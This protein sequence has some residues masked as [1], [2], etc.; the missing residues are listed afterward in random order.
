MAI[1]INSSDILTVEQLQSHIKVYA[2][3][4]AGKTHFLVEN[5]KNIVTINPLVANSRA[6]K[7]LCI[8]YTNAAVEEIVRRLDRFSDAVEAYTI[9]GFIIEHIIKPFQNDLRVL[10][11]KYFNIEITGNA[12]ITSQVEGLGILHGRDKDEIYKY[13]TDIAS[14]SAQP[15]Y[16]KKT[17]SE[18]QIDNEA[19][20]FDGTIKL[21]ESKSVDVN[22][23]LPIKQY[24]WSVVRM[25]THD[26]ILFFGYQIIKNNPTALYALRVKFP[27][28]FVDE[29]QDTN[30]LQTLLLKLI[31]EKSTVI[32][33]IGD[34]AQSIYSFQGAKPSQFNNF[35]VDGSRPLAEYVINGNRRSNANIV[36]FCNFLRQS[37]TNVHQTSIRTDLELKKVHFLLGDSNATKETIS[38]VLQDGGVVLTRAWAKAFAY[39]QG[40]EESQ[41]KLLTAIYNSYYSSPIDIRA[42]IVEMNNVTWVRAFRFIFRMYEAYLTSSFVD[43]LNALKLYIDIDR[44]K[45]NFSTMR[46]II[47]LGK[48][49]FANLTD[50]SFT[51]E[52]IK[53]FNNKLGEMVYLDLKSKLLG[54]DFIVPIFDEYDLESD[55]K[56]SQQFIDNLSS[57]TWT[58]SYKLFTE[59]FSPESKYMTVHQSKGLEWSKVIVSVTPNNFDKIKLPAVYTNPQILNEEPADEF[60]R[61][62]YVA[63]SRAKEDLYIHLPSDFDQS[64]ISKALIGKDVQYEI[65]V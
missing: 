58:T 49:V 64:N 51:V 27:F 32:G 54:E 44:K 37:D 29:F 15:T 19:F 5:V 17:M 61:M 3:P 25:L 22:H 20:A 31:G 24:V 34:V 4:G 45:L 1:E 47:S 21:T 42:E 10:I 6:R 41:V 65:I 40:V 59:V 18:V 62:Y 56:K 39:M 63:C 57:L 16:S 7:V 14:T 38:A 9:H 60:M 28:I 8:T 35:T 50:T 30:P 2:G 55:S 52:V 46:Q 43:A 23:K 33:I 12:P 36:N 26:E 53:Q 48:E 11:Q 13:I